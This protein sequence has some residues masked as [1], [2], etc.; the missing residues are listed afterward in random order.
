MYSSESKKKKVLIF[1]NR[2]GLWFLI[3]FLV[4]WYIIVQTCVKK[5]VVEKEKWYIKIQSHKARH[6]WKQVA[7]VV[8]LFVC[9]R[10]AI[11]VLY[12]SIV[13]MEAS[14]FVSS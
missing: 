14:E 8:C 13:G 12:K 11:W 5:V 7:N 10:G 6:G 9:L 3:L 4:L 1:L 2:V